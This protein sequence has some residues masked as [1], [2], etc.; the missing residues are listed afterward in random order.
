[1]G[2]GGGDGGWEAA[3]GKKRECGPRRAT[4]HYSQPELQN[5][6]YHLALFLAPPTI[7]HPLPTF[8]YD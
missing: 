2:M 4:Y 6:K 5:A 7:R 3:G 1:M 8:F